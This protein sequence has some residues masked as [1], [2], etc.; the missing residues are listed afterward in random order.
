M[1]V[2]AAEIRRDDAIATI[3]IKPLSKMIELGFQGEEI[4]ETSVAVGMA[5]EEL[6]YDDSVRVVVITGS[7]DGEFYVVPP[8][9]FYH[10]PRQEERVATWTVHGRA[11][12][13]SL[14]GLE[15][16]M[17]ALVLIDKP[18][19]ARVNGDA[20]SFGQSVMFGC[21]IIVARE[22]AI[23][24]D[25]HLSQ[26]TF[27]DHTGQL[28]GLPYSLSPGDGVISFLPHFLPPTKAKEYLFLGA[29]WS[30]KELAAMNI[31]NHAVPMSE[32]DQVLDDITG[33][34][35]QRDARALARA[36]RV[37][38]KALVGQWNLAMDLLVSAEKL[39]VYEHANDGWKDE[40]SLHGGKGRD[41]KREG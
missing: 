19:I 22:D 28:R 14:Q 21:D 13:W 15:R 41:G 40:L 9:D 7:E 38:N 11:V 31:V 20:T 37:Y 36:K 25:V 30:T 3:L 32:L 2:L 27:K 39:D 10:D 24:S 17:E 35:L 18:V 8:P 16:T 23:V 12:P 29:S 33:R 6:R 5:L 1:T 34:L 4:I 26:G